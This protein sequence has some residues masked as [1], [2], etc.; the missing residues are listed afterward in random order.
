MKQLGAN[1][2]ARRR[3]CEVRFSIAT[4]NRVLQKN[5]MWIGMRKAVEDGFGPYE[6]LGREAICISATKKVEVE[7]TDCVSSRKARVG[8]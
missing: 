6:S 1:E 5:F 3:K 4:R 7:A 2:T 8:F